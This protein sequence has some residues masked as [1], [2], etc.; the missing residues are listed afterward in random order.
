MVFVSALLL[1]CE[2]LNV[3]VLLMVV[4]EQRGYPVCGGDTGSERKGIKG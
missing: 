4:S 1:F 3:Q 2:K